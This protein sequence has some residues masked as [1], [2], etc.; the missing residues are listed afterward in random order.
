MNK[1]LPVFVVSL[2]VLIPN[3]INADQSETESDRKIEVAD[4]AQII[5][6]ADTAQT[7]D[8]SQIVVIVNPTPEQV[9]SL[10]KQILSPET[11]DEGMQEETSSPEEVEETE[12]PVLTTFDIP[13]T[14]NEKVE[15]Y[16]H[17]FTNR[18]RD[19]FSTWLGRSEM[20]LPMMKKTFR[21]KG[22]PED[23]TYLVLIESGFNNRAYSRAK[24]TGQWQFM[25]GTGKRYGLRIDRW[26]DERRDP[27]K[28]TEA[29]AEYLGDLY[30]LFNDWHLAAAGYNAGAGKIGRAIKKYKTD[31]FWQ[32][33]QPKYKYLRRETKDYVPKLIAAAMI[34]KE[35]AKYGFDDIEYHPSLAYEKVT[36]NRMTDLR[37]ISSAAECSLE[38]VQTLNPALKTKFTPP[39]YP[40]YEL[41]VP[42]GKKEI[43]E[44]RLASI[45]GVS[46]KA[47]LR[48]VGP[49][50]NS[51]SRKKSSRA[52][53]AQAQTVSIETAS[54]GV[55]SYIVKEGDT[56]W[57][58]AA[59]YSVDVRHLASWNN[60][61][62]QHQ[63]KT[64]QRLNIHVGRDAGK[65]V[66]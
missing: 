13:M 26:I 57:G 48:E 55:I 60:L 35:P 18:I 24:A 19:K 54:K 2:T 29:A 11:L 23:L 33:S 42:M 6:T 61:R 37:D 3:I 8:D 63:L 27:E 30:G 14:T 22:L 66:S 40:D 16:I 31:D 53:R 36:I 15:I 39:N 25:K 9:L 59:K 41:N 1:L 49:E 56:L 65:K 12:V 38:D 50:K 43:L 62:N 32:L 51:V 46:E 34:A 5:D 17:Y 21:E 20:Y 10:D 52:K 4:S 28:A 44:D 58:I 7:L 64:G 47:A 45:N